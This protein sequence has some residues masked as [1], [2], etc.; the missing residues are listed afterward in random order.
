M[1]SSEAVE[2]YH[3][4]EKFGIMPGLERI[5]ILC[6]R[7]GS[8]HKK[9]KFV[10][11]AGTNGKGS[12]C[13]ALASVLTEAG[14]KTGLYT[15][16][17]VIDFR[18]RIQLDMNMISPAELAEVTEKVS[19][20]INELSEEGIKITEFEAVT[21]AAFTYYAEKNCDIVVLETG[22]GG[23]FDATNIIPSPLCSIITSVSLDHVNVLGS[24]LEKIAYEKCG[25]IKNGCPV[26]TGCEQPPQVHI[27]IKECAERKNAQ[28]ILADASRVF[29]AV[30]E[31]ITGTEVVCK[32]GTFLVPWTGSHQLNNMALV[33]SA[34]E[35]L[36]D[37]GFRISSDAFC[38]GISKARIPART[39]IISRLPLVIL[40]GSHNDGST[41]ALADV[42]K[43][44]LHGK[45]ILAVMGMM[46]DKDCRTVLSNLIPLFSKVITVRPSNPRSMAPDELAAIAESFFVKAVSCEAPSDGI[47][48]AFAEISDFDA[49][50]VCGSLYLAGDVRK[51]L[52]EIFNKNEI[53]GG[54]CYADE[55]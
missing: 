48:V 42:I 32:D 16:P 19:A 30:S 35:V 22:L 52:Y 15:S 13:T 31:N 8:P 7:L 25:I 2:Y 40:D 49:L 3:S 10:H 6:E 23:R 34:V 21:S 5:N 51:T 28:L 4:L 41:K 43:K 36:R 27:T 26:V 11:V 9:L 53:I 47:R 12:T 39:E 18:E 38:N 46:A 45:K 37:E 54:K 55:S 29:T 17:Y 24:T 44:Y 50:V 1:T 33:L 20:V 14:Y